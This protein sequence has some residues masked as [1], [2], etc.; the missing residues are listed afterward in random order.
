MQW[1]P[2]NSAI[3]SPD[4]PG[5]F[6]SSQAL[7]PDLQRNRRDKAMR[8]TEHHLLRILAA[9]I[10]AAVETIAEERQGSTRRIVVSIPDRKLILIDNGRI[11]KT[12]PVVVGSPA[13]PRPVGSFQPPFLLRSRQHRPHHRAGST[14]PRL[15]WACGPVAGWGPDPQETTPQ[16]RPRTCRT[17]RVFA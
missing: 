12:Y 17:I 2:V 1:L 7:A 15:W 5:G 13:T 3:A 11:V 4:L 10:V 8:H 6:F 16:R 14:P 9:M